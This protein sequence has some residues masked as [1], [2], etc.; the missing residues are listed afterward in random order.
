MMRALLVVQARGP[1]VAEV[2]LPK[3]LKALVVDEVLSAFVMDQITD[4]D[5][6]VRV[7]TW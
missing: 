5:L 6:V 2:L 7:S 4:A 1:V 3:I